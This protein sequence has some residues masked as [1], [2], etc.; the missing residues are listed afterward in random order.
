[1]AISTSDG[2]FFNGFFFRLS[3]L[4]MKKIIEYASL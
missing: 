1:L 4:D 3:E 2:D